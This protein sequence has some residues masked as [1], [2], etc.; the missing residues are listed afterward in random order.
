MFSLYI[1][2]IWIGVT[3]QISLD[4][5][6]VGYLIGLF[7][8]MVLHHLGIGFKRSVGPGHLLA[9]LTYGGIILWDGLMSSIQVVKLVLSPKIELKTGILALQTGDKSPD[10]PLAALSAHG[11]NMTPREIVIDFDNNGTLYIHCLDLERARATLETE[12]RRRLQ[13]LRRIL[14]VN[15]DE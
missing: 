13:L 8:L 6:L 12:Q 1:G 4:S 7:T 10:Q 11:I 9:V 14:G 2:L 3:G 5:F 15:E